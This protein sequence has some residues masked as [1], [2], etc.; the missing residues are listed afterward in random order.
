MSKKSYLSL[1]GIV[2]GYLLNIKAS[3]KLF[4]M[5]LENKKKLEISLPKNIRDLI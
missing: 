1:L 3:N 5:D 2:I 4:L